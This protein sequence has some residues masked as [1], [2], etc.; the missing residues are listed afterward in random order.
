MLQVLTSAF[1]VGKQLAEAEKALDALKREFGE[2]LIDG[3]KPVFD[4]KRS[5]DYD[6]FWNWVVQDAMEL[7]YHVLASVKVGFFFP[8]KRVY[9]EAKI[10]ARKGRYQCVDSQRR[11]PPFPRHGRMDQG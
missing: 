8:S 6:S 7:H 4:S 1:C 9:W 3:V 11:A 5:R 10:I 2:A